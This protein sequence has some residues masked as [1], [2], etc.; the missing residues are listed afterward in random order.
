M[1]S[2]TAVKAAGSSD[3]FSK[4]PV[5]SGMYKVDGAWQPRE[6]ITLRAWPGYWDKDAQKLGGID[7]TEVAGEAQLNAIQAGDLDLT[8]LDN[9][10]ATSLGD[11]YNVV[12]QDSN[13]YSVFLL[14][15]AAAPIDNLMVRQAIA[16]AIDRQAIADALTNGAAKAAYQPFPTTSGAYD[17]DLAKLYPYDPAKAKALLAQAGYPN[18]FDLKAGVG[19][20][21][22]LYLQM[23]ELIAGQLKQVGINMTITQVDQSQAFS[24]I[25][26]KGMFQGAPYGGQA[27]PDIAA[28]FRDYYLKGGTINASHIESPGVS[29]LITQAGSSIDQAAR[30]DAFKKA[31]QI[32]TQQVQGGV[33]LYFQP[34]VE[35]YPKYVGGVTPGQLAC[36][37]NF[38]GIYITQNK[39]NA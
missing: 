7:M 24:Q 25:V 1:A 2:P 4:A 38:R 16:Y 5:G 33:V 30:S 3:A 36:Q 10:P 11:K 14:N 17:A 8:I 29:D 22:P 32:I 37:F 31:N 6:K 12:T 20:A 34:S 15:S 26:S 21:S 27:V 39:V 9:K 35:V 23:G 18:G 13:Q 28:Q 19:N